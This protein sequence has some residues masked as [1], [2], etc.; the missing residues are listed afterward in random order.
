MINKD[1]MRK[2]VAGLRSGEYTQTKSSLCRI[3]PITKGKYV[4]PAGFCCL[5]VA[6]EVAIKEGVDVVK[7][8]GESVVYYDHETDHLPRKVRGWLGLDYDSPSV[9]FIEC[10][11]AHATELVSLNDNIGLDFNAIA[12]LI[13]QEYNL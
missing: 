2:W 12:K 1:N 10:G 3:E 5:G 6:C 8:I 11:E 13:E 9:S 4:S 7:E